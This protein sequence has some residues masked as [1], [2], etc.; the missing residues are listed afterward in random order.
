MRLLT[1]TLV[2]DRNKMFN[3]MSVWYRKMLKFHNSVLRLFYKGNIEGLHCNIAIYHNNT[4]Y[5]WC[6][7]GLLIMTNPLRTVP[8]NIHMCNLF[9]YYHQ[10][11]LFY[12]LPPILQPI[13]EKVISLISRGFAKNIICNIQTLYYFLSISK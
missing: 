7:C 3:F 4:I 9:R 12:I 13:H 11:T 5:A 6:E 10:R 8:T 1:R 2:H